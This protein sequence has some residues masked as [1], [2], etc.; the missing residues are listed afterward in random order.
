M[1]RGTQICRGAGRATQVP[2]DHMHVTS[3]VTLGHS[4]IQARIAHLYTAAPR[5]PSLTCITT[6]R[7]YAAAATP[8]LQPALAAEL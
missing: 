6:A 8:L 1:S 5:L 4:Q 2:P 7:T 3:F